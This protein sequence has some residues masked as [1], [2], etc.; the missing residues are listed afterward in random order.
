MS[1]PSHIT[2]IPIT[3]R[4]QL[5]EVLASGE[6]PA[7]QWRIGTEHEKFGFRLDDL[8]PPTFDDERGIE[9]L[10]TGMTRFG[11]TPVQEHDR[12]IAL[13]RGDTSITLEPAGQLELAGAPLE[14]IH[15]THIEAETHLREVNEIAN[16][17]Q[18]GFIGMGFHPK[19]TRAQMPWMPKGRYAIMRAY[20]PK[21]GQ[22]GL[23]MMTRTCTVQ[24]NLDYASETD[25]VKKFRVSLALQPIAT[26]LFANSPFT[27]GK[28]NG[29][30]SYRSHIWTD[31]D[32][33]RTGMLDFVFEDGFGYERYVDYLLDVPMYFSYR[34]G[35]YHDASGQSFRDF[36]QGRLPALPGILPTLRDWSDHMTTAFPEVRL[37]KYIEMRGADSGPLP[38]LCA[39]PAFWVGLLYDNTALDAAWDLIKDLTLQE[40]HA[41]RNGVPRHALAL[42]FRSSTVRTLALQTLDI[43]R[44]GLRRRAQHNANGQDE[45][46]FLNV[47]DEIAHSGQTPAQ[48]KLQLYE[49]TWNHDINPIF[50]D[51]AY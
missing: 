37:K 28:P 15:Q 49:S 19:C 47:L 12:T 35:I 43:S 8:R 22:L 50:N 32:P 11:W 18:L 36:L 27:E 51:Y 31:T 7:S 48:R 13:L 46:I 21:V 1:S 45:T 25:M 33:D 24:V 17:L 41:L 38:T 29:Y 6:K 44:A 39:L 9:A 34:T 2:E 26:A 30:L 10:L 3:N 5:V 4:A 14:T 20:M 40:R 23:D 16:T 42:P